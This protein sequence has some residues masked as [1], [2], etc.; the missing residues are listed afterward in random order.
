MP[1]PRL[2]RTWHFACK[3]SA[4]TP[5][6]DARN[7]MLTHVGRVRAGAAGR[8]Q[9]ARGACLPRARARKPH[10]PRRLVSKGSCGARVWLLCGS[11]MLCRTE[12]RLRVALTT[13]GSYLSTCLM[14]P[15]S[16]SFTSHVFSCCCFVLTRGQRASTSS[17]TWTGRRCSVLPGMGVASALLSAPGALHAYMH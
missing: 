4:A 17:P 8:I 16:L 6:F 12:P 7:C 3:R 13:G 11:D 10:Q 14:V 15:R 9:C 5:P 2:G 1:H